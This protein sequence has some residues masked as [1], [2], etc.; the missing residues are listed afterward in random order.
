MV[1]RKCSLN[2]PIVDECREVCWQ[3]FV[4][5]EVDVFECPPA[6]TMPPM[7]PCENP[8]AVSIQLTRRG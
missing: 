7:L 2:P 1:A 5:A 3:E 6:P 4:G 8:P